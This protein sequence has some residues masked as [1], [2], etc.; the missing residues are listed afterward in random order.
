MGYW[1]IFIQFMNLHHYIDFIHD[2]V[3]LGH[4]NGKSDDPFSYRTGT[5]TDTGFTEKLQAGSAVTGS[6][7]CRIRLLYDFL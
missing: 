4:R 2:N 5:D 6:D 7:R 1:L 3:R